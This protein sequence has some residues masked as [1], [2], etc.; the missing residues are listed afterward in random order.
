VIEVGA[1]IVRIGKQRLPDAGKRP[2][3]PEEKDSVTI[4]I[5][6]ASDASTWKLQI[7]QNGEL[8]VQGKTIV[9]KATQQLTL[10]APKVQVKCDSMDVVDRP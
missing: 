3:D 1:L 5:P 4:E 6:G 7:K 10:D 9:I 2:D 8:T